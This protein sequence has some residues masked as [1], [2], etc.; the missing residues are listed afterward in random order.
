MATY[1]RQ[2][3]GLS[4]DDALTFLQ[5][6]GAT[7]LPDEGPLPDSHTELLTQL[8]PDFLVVA[9]DTTADAVRKGNDA[10]FGGAYKT[11]LA[12]YLRI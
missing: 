2:A 12:E 7:V 5:N 1:Y 4:N 6:E 3:G 9:G 8:A 10:R 11:P